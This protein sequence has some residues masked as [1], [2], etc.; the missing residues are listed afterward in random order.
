M[1]DAGAPRVLIVVN[2]LSFGGTERMLERLVVRLSESGRAAFTVVSL[3]E[4]GP[5]GDRL[6]RRGVEVI[7]LGLRGGAARIVLGGARRL[8]RLLRARR[9]DLLHTFLYRSHVAGR[10]ARLRQ[11]EAPP[12]LSSERCVGDNRGFVV[13]AANR[14]TAGMSDRFLAVSRAVRDRVVE[15]DG[16]APDRVQVIL[17]G[18]EEAEPRPRDRDRLRRRLGI[19]ARDTVLLLLG[20][21][22]REKGPDL[23][24]RALDLLARSGV[25]GWRALVVGEGPERET[26]ESSSRRLGLDRRLFFT[27]ARCRVGPWIDAADLL[28]LPSREEGMPVAAMEAMM[29]GKPVLAARVGGVPEVVVDGTTGVL[30]APGDAEA[31][32]SALRGLLSDRGRLE[33]LGREGRRVARSE[34]SL[35]RMSEAIAAVYDEM[36]RASL[37]S[38]VH[39]AGRR[40]ARAGRA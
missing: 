39:A 12:L 9:F 20:R 35:A 7:A 34:F 31:L 10:L 13:S 29:K 6:S 2:S 16:V 22:H 8:R 32:A 38:P 3:E 30:V 40:A 19:P 26:L 25:A 27:G 28:V 17:N 11:P 24:L 18:I 23:L 1:A 37:P 14:L 15:R 33:A 4:R 21:L 5:V 36:T